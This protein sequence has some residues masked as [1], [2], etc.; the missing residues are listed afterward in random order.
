MTD[1]ILRDALITACDWLKLRGIVINTLPLKTL[2]FFVRAAETL[3]RRLYM[4]DIDQAEFEDGMLDLMD[5]Q[6]TRAWNE[7]MRI[8]GLD[9][10][11]D[12]T[13]E[14]E[15]ALEEI[16]L[17][18]VDYIPGFATAI[19]DAAKQD[20][21]NGT[22]KES[23]PLLYSRAGLWAQRYPDV[24]SRAVV[25]TA[26]GKD[27]LKW[28][29]GDTDHCDTCLRLNGIVA[30]ASEWQL[31]GVQPQNPDN[32]VLDCHGWN[33]QCTLEPTDEPRSNDAFDKIMAALG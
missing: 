15:Q 7:G 10:E 23:L 9:P 21:A 24:V 13:A 26:A 22:P 32:P 31:A 8:N 29:F 3:T 4:G 28:V 6:L 25:I 2:G 30:F 27:R 19:V 11:R 17:N 18:E 16:K 5:S 12:M 33:C 20:A 1:A 14:W